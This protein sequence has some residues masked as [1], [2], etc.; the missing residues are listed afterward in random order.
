MCDSLSGTC[1]EV[2]QCDEAADELCFLDPCSDIECS[3]GDTC[4]PATAQCVDYENFL[5][6]NMFDN[7]DLYEVA[8]HS[9]SESE[10]VEEW[11]ELILELCEDL[12]PAEEDENGNDDVTG[13]ENN[14]RDDPEEF[15]DDEDYRAPSSTRGS[16]DP[17][18]AACGVVREVRSDV[19]TI[20]RFIQRNS[21][22][23]VKKCFMGSGQRLALSPNRGVRPG[24]GGYDI[25]TEFGQRRGGKWEQDPA[26]GP[27]NGWNKKPD[28][29]KKKKKT[30]RPPHKN[31]Q[32]PRTAPR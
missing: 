14:N 1:E 6:G 12:Y 21:P 26:R 2:Q 19:H 20:K 24:R 9:Y 8:C 16:T 7:P 31:R 18:V 5:F 4:D 22:S 29:K 30:S 23:R 15:E 25:F 3:E 27:K 17:L 32:T 11:G 13:D 28:K 10:L